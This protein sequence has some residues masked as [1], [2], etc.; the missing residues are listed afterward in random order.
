MLVLLAERAPEDPR[1]F[2]RISCG[3]DEYSLKA[4]WV[5]EAA[6]E[7]HTVHEVFRGPIA[8]GAHTVAAAFYLRPDGKQVALLSAFRVR[9]AH[10]ETRVVRMALQPGSRPIVGRA[11]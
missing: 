4:L 8:A 11:E 6:G 1:R 7:T 9:V 10:G 2:Q 5:S 3:I